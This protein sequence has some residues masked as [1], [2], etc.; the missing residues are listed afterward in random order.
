MFV[1]ACVCFWE[2]GSETKD[3]HTIGK[4]GFEAAE[5][6]KNLGL[7][8][9]SELSFNSHMK[10]VSKSD[11]YHFYHKKNNKT[12]SNDT[13]RSSKPIDQNQKKGIDFKVLLLA[14][15]SL[16]GQGPLYSRDV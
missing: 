8:I 1:Y 13:K 2:K 11:F 16:N 10:A 9:D 14:F 5:T 6:V 7:I 15:K 4:E 12:T 3:C